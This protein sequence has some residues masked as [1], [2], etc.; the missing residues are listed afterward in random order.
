MFDVIQWVNNRQHSRTTIQT[1]ST[2]DTDATQMFHTPAPIPVE[3]EEFPLPLPTPG[4]EQ[5]QTRT[6]TPR[7]AVEATTPVAE[8]ASPADGLITP[9]AD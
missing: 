3:P 9:R 6:Q 8:L 2:L 1:I 4:E 7:P 5:P